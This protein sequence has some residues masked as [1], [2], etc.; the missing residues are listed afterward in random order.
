MGGL[1]SIVADVRNR[2]LRSRGG[3]L[4]ALEGAC[5]EERSAIVGLCRIEILSAGGGAAES[6]KVNAVRGAV[7][8]V[9]R[10]ACR[11]RRAVPSWVRAAHR[12]YVVGGRRGGGEWQSQCGPGGRAVGGLH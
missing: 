4:R 7:H 5:S 11:V 2:A 12:G 10:G 3:V 9:V 6:G 1:R 8:R